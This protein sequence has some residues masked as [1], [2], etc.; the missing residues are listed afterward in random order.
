MRKYSTILLN[1]VLTFAL[2]QAIPAYIADI[3]KLIESVDVEEIRTTI[4]DLQENVDLDPPHTPYR[5]R[6]TLR[7]ENTN[8]PS[9]A[10]L[11]NAAEYLFRKLSSY[12]LEVEYD[13]FTISDVGKHDGFSGGTYEAKNVVATLQ[14][15]GSNRDLVYIICAHYDSCGFSDPGWFEDENWK[16]M[17][18]PGANDNASGVSALVE[19]ARILSRSEFGATVKFIALAGHEVGMFGSRHYAQAA[20]GN[21]NIIGVLSVDGIGYEPNEMDMSILGKEKSEWLVEA[22]YAARRDYQIDLIVDDEFSLG[23]GVADHTSFWNAGFDAVM[24]FFKGTDRFTGP[25]ALRDWG[26]HSAKDTIDNLNM[27]FMSRVT[28]LV[29]ATAAELANPLVVDGVVAAESSGKLVATW[30]KIRRGR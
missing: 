14:G 20:K 8:N 11:D 2:C 15:T 5:S 4:L 22:V 29:V 16:T 21:E 17:A 6:F 24:F 25:Q 9:D 26:Y 3:H 7:V 23:G 18:A 13:P 10:A 12:G 30:G 28:Q 19:A 1:L 27:E